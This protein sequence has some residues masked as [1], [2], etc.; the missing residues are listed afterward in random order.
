M[1]YIDIG[2]LNE[3]YCLVIVPTI[4][5]ILSIPED[6]RFFHTLINISRT[7]IFINSV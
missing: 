4:G 7:R 3:M 1:Y 6:S 2:T 5:N